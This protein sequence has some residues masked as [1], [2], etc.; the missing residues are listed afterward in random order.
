MGAFA[1]PLLLF[2]WNPSPIRPNEPGP[3]LNLCRSGITPCQSEVNLQVGGQ[4]TVDVVIEPVHPAGSRQD[5]TL[6][7]WYLEL[8]LDRVGIVTISPDPATGLPFE[9]RGPTELVLNGWNP[10]DSGFSLSGQPRPAYYRF[11]NN[12]DLATG[13]LQYGV[14]LLEK[15][16]ALRK[17]T[18]I[19]LQNRGETRIARITLDAAKAGETWFLAGGTPSSSPTL[20]ITDHRGR[21]KTL[22]LSTDHPLFRVN[23]G[24]DA[25]GLR[26]EG[27]AWTALPGRKETRLPFIGTLEIEIWEANVLPATR[28]E[29]DLPLVKFTGVVPDLQGRFVIPDLPADLVPP[30]AYDVR[31]QGRGSLSVVVPDVPFS[32]LGADPRESPQVIEVDIGPLVIGD[33]SGDNQIDASDLVLLK[34]AFGSV[35]GDA[36]FEEMGDF[37][38]DGVVDAQDF[39]RAAASFGH[40]GE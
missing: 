1:L 16:P 10:V 20:L 31:A 13:A 5:D 4:V 18:G 3:T 27:Q 23:V 9:E 35:A 8:F 17:P 26:L 12:L 32:I 28:A 2:F 25:E 24:Q 40:R 37:N 36:N 29:S 38:Y 15:E 21:N 34:T 7:A 30:G 14:V 19:P 11:R 39:S 22:L 33:L 6:A